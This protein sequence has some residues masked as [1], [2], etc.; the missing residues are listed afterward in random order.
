TVVATSPRSPIA[1]TLRGL[2]GWSPGRED[3][4]DSRAAARLAVDLKLAAE[5]LDPLEHAGEA[6][7]TK[8]GCVEERGV[9][10]EATPVIFD[11]HRHG[12]FALD[13]GDPN[14]LCAA[15]LAD[16]RQ[17]LADDLEDDDPPGL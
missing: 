10:V 5:H 14:V 12:S 2:V 11:G 17:G 15:V 13:D 7:A 9:S 16:V 8:D 6:E 1:L 4:A 3:E